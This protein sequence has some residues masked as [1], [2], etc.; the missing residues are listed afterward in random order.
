MVCNIIYIES[1]ICLA[2]FDKKKV[3]YVSSFCLAIQF[4]TILLFVYNLFEMQH[5]LINGNII[6]KL[7]LIKL[8]NTLTLV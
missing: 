7:H 4:F 5:V 6:S 8:V 3:H 2:Y 1:F